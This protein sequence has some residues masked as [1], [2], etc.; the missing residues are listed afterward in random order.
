M[1]ALTLWPAYA[2][3]IAAGI[4]RIETRCR[5]IHL[6]GPIAIHAGMHDTLLAR[7]WFERTLGEN[8]DDAAA[9]AKLG[10]Y[11]YDDLPKG[12]IVA[13]A[14]VVGCSHCAVLMTRGEISAQEER[15]GDFRTEDRDRWGWRLANVRRCEL[16]TIIRGKQSFWPVPAELAAQLAA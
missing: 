10:I 6:R 2:M 12:R 3:A 13:V 11:S 9:F 16:P 8:A 14:D 15:W 4:K 1:K 7:G 5:P